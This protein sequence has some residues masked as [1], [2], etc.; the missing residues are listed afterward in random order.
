M[1]VVKN[2]AKGGGWLAVKGAG[3]RLRRSRLAT[4]DP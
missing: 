4:G 2:R 1:A 3:K